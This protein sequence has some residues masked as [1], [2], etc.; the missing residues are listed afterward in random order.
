MKLLGITN[1]EKIVASVARH[2]YISC[3]GLMADG[4]QLF[5]GNNTGYNRF[6]SGKIIWVEVSQNFAELYNDWRE[7]CRGKK[8]KYGIWNKEE[9][10]ILSLEEHP[11]IQSFEWKAENAIWGTRG[12]NGDQPL[13]YVM[14]KD[15]SIEHLENIRDF[16]GSHGENDLIKIIDFWL[17]Q[18]C[19]ERYDHLD[20]RTS[21]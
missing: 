5:I 18:K 21:A 9:V 20:S 17:S 13:K 8:R 10:K 6:S 3:D 2:D 14:I 11:D 15:C 12:I 16:L 19:K 4:G 1:G 7:S